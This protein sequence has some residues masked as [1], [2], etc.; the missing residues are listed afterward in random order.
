MQLFIRHKY[1]KINPAHRQKDFHAQYLKKIPITK[2]S[3]ILKVQKLKRTNE[4]TVN[5]ME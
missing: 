5:T 1:I 3:N 4:D 2:Y